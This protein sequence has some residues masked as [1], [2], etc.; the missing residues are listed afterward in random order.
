MKIEEGNC[1]EKLAEIESNI[2]DLIYLDPPFFTQKTHSLKNRENTKEYSFE[3]KW[4]SITEYVEFI[5]QVLKEC[6]RVLKNTGSIFLHCDKIA[7]H[8]L[9]IALDNIFGIVNFQSEI[10]WSY[11][12]WSNS[13]KGLL[14][15]HQ[16]IYFYSKSIDF[17]FNTLFTDYSP[18][19]N[20]DQILQARVRN[21]N[22]KTTYMKDEL[23]DLVLSKEKKGVPLSDVWNIPYLNP[24]AKE[25][26]GYPTQKPVLLL[27]QIIKIAS[28]EGDLILDPFCGSGTTLLAAKQLCRDFIGFD[29][30]SEAIELTKNRLNE[31]VISSSKLLNLGENSYIGHSEKELSILNNISAL[32]VQRN[33]GIDGILSSYIDKKPVAIK[34]QKE[35]ETL[36]ESKN[37]LINSTKSDK[38]YKYKILVK[39]NNLHE[40]L[41]FDDVFEMDNE[42]IIIIDSYDILI[43]QLLKKS[44]CLKKEIHA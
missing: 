21:N 7:S 18:T 36:S 13:K 6:K 27:S 26:S 14:N 28:N 32:A 38:Y 3:D 9:R 33:S 42:N 37:K 44:K 1:L 22:G 4:E 39:T 2:V 19:T 43:N 15:S 8:Y 24:K 34:I 40:E 31:M 25:R 12:R 10:I 30:S 41:L 23:G 35:N 20:L 29:I 17:K 16:T 5:S 11:K